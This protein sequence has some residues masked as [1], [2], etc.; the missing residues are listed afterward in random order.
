MA[1]NVE[2]YSPVYRELA[3][4]LGDH[5][6]F[7]IWKNYAGLT[8]SF[9]SRLYDRRYIRSLVAANMGSMKPSAIARMVGLSDRRVRQ[10]MHELKEAKK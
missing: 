2:Q 5:A 1:K 3:E 7:L 6:A 8:V 4:L 9:P 10:I